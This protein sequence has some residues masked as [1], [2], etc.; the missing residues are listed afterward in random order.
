MYLFKPSKIPSVM[1][2]PHLHST[3]YLFKPFSYILTSFFCFIYIP[4][5]IYLNLKDQLHKADG[6]I[7]LHSTMYLFKH[8]IYMSDEEVGIYLHSTMYLFKQ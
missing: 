7:N 8:Y 2:P 6:K 4:P 3:M 1:Y 5:C